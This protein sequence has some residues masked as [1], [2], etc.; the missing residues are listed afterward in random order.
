MDRLHTGGAISQSW[1]QIL[2]FSPDIKFNVFIH[3]MVSNMSVCPLGKIDVAVEL[4]ITK[5]KKR[6]INPIKKHDLQVGCV[7]LWWF[8]K[9]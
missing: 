4:C 1:R 3:N 8:C 6:A 5:K 2:R 9:M 7:L